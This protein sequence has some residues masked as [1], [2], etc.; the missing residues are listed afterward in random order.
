MAWTGLSC[1]NLRV[2]EELGHGRRCVTSPIQ[3]HTSV[4]RANILVVESPRS[5]GTLPFSDA[6]ER[7]FCGIVCGT[8]KTAFRRGPISVER[9]HEH[10]NRIRDPSDP[11]RLRR[12]D[13][14]V[15]HEDSGTYPGGI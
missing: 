9:L 6:T 12:I 2:L 10:G 15:A 7:S 11:P 3:C 8:M 13:C 5:F 1:V 14:D 4:L